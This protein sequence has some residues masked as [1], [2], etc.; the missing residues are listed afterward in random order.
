MAIVCECDDC[1]K[2]YR[3]KQH[4][5]GTRIPCRACGYLIDVPGTRARSRRE[6]QATNH[7][8]PKVVI[9]I[10]AAVCVALGIAFAVSVAMREQKT[11][12]VL[13]DHLLD[14]NRWF[15]K[16]GYAI[17][18]PTT[19]RSG[20]V[21]DKLTS[22][23]AMWHPAGHRTSSIKMDIDFDQE[24]KATTR[25]RIETEVD[26]YT[27][28]PGDRY[29][30]GGGHHEV[31]DIAGITFDKVVTTDIGPAQFFFVAY[32]DGARV[33]ITGRTDEGIDSET[34]K[35]LEAV[36]GTFRQRSE[37]VTIPQ[38]VSFGDDVSQTELFPPRQ[39]REAATAPPS[40]VLQA[41]KPPPEER[42]QQ[43]I[44]LPRK[45]RE[46]GAV[47]GEGD[48]F[49]PMPE[50][51]RSDVC[52]S[53]SPVDFL[54]I[55]GHVYDV[56]SGKELAKLRV[57]K[58][59]DH[60]AI[61]DD[62]RWYAVLP[63]KSDELYVFSVQNPDGDP[64]NIPLD[65]SRIEFLHFAGED[66]LLASCGRDMVRVWSPVDGKLL[67]EFEVER[68]EEN[69]GAI[70]P[71]GRYLAAIDVRSA[72]VFDVRTGRKVARLET[73][74]GTSSMPYHFC[75]GIAFSPDGSELAALL[76]E[77]RLVVWSSH[78]RVVINE[79]LEGDPNAMRRTAGIRWLADGS[80]WFLAGTD[81]VLR[82]SMMVV[83]RAKRPSFYHDVPS[84]VVDQ[85]HVLV[86]HNGEMI[87]VPIPWTE[88]MPR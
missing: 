88:S 26:G 58:E 49:F 35:T 6:Q 76:H 47:W 41:E 27:S 25:A 5:A 67:K 21:K 63:R 14:R 8:A 70:S 55:D 20:S 48:K 2:K 43:S 74:A 18:V 31:V 42:R 33:E 45:R 32:F 85:N 80:G 53:G 16:G 68:F 78:G 64:I 22:F 54:G 83:W 17:N 15:G 3:V 10:M 12:V 34:W 71:D 1:G 51:H 46:P 87:G 4:R 28:G 40:G 44:S 69:E 37:G 52:V 79:V 57:P 30:F 38:S 72:G 23:S 82:D 36:A 24:H 7:I 73:P 66:R 19:F 11:T 84:S 77:R 75:S 9:G 59:L 65:G 50:G 56:A 29:L 86:S 81:I 62:G 60:S 39:S 13:D 61:S